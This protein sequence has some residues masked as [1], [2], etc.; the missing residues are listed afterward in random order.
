M[1]STKGGDMLEMEYRARWNNGGLWFQGSGTYNPNG[2]LGGSTGAQTYGHL[3]GSPGTGSMTIG[4]S[5]ST[6]RSPATAP[7]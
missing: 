5:V 2:G 4:A 3:F 6:S 7:I 1:A